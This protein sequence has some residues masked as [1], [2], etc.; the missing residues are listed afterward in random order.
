[1][2]RGKTGALLLSWNVGEGEVRLREGEAARPGLP[3]QSSRA[4][5]RDHILSKTNNIVDVRI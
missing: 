2:L 5:E 3:I 1:M 4:V